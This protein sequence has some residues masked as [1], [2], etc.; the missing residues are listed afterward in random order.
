MIALVGGALAAEV[1]PVSAQSFEASADGRAGLGVDDAIVAPSGQLTARALLQYVKDPLVY[2]VGDGP[3]VAA[4]SDLL[5]VDFVTSYTIGRARVGFDIPF[6]IGTWGESAAG[7]G[8]LGDVAVD[9]RYSV[10]DTW[11]APIGLAPSARIAIPTALTGSGVGSGGLDAHLGLVASRDAGPWL[12]AVN[13]AVHVLPQVALANGT[14]GS[15]LALRAGVAR[16]LGSAGI[17]G[18]LDGGVGLDDPASHA[19]SPLEARV[20]GWY[21][22]KPTM[23]IRGAVGTGLTRGI[24]APD[25]RVLLGASFEPSLE[26]DTDHDRYRDPEDDCPAAPEDRDGFVDFDGCPDPDDDEDGI[27]DAADRCPR[28]PEDADGHEDSDGCPDPG[29]L[30]RFHARDTEGRPIPTARTILD[31]RSMSGADSEAALEVGTWEIRVEAPGYVAVDGQ[32]EVVAGPA[33]DHTV[34]LS[35]APPPGPSP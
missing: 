22:V 3:E 9:L 12:F 7:G 10:L 20:G 6:Y 28:E 14:Y 1:A 30:V 17:T 11:N 4:I 24:G 34:R 26:R 35:R 5:A 23:V 33:I 21:R 2:R 29:A 16:E 18:E 27:L 8:L 15:Q 13:A 25:A 19:T 32:V 31:A